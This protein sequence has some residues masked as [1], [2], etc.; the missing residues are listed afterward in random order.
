MDAQKKQVIAKLKESKNILVTVSNNPSIDQLAACLGLSLMLNKLGKHASAVFSGEIPSTLDFLKPEETL[1]TNTNSLRDFI[2]ALDRNKADKLR[3]KVEDKVVRIFITPYRTSISQDDLN[4]SEG[5][6]NVDVVIAL[7]VKAQQDIDRA[8]TEHGNIL[9]DA[10]VI[11]LTTGDEPELGS[12]HWRDP[13]ASGV[14][15]LAASLADSFD[16]NVLDEQIA[17]AF[18]T[19][20]VARTNRFS[21]ELTSS[22]T[23]KI[24][25]QLMGA[26]A[27]QQLV[28]SELDKPAESSQQ[29][30]VGELP[31]PQIS[32]EVQ[33]DNPVDPGLLKIDHEESGDSSQGIEPSQ[34]EPNQPPEGAKAEPEEPQK[35][36]ERGRLEGDGPNDSLLT[37]N[38]KEE[39]LEGTT[40][41]LSLADQGRGL[42]SHGKAE[43]QK[44]E[45]VK[46]EQ[47]SPK[48]T[49]ET[50][51]P[52]QNDNPD[53]KSD[54]HETL[55]ELEADVHSPHL[56]GTTG[57]DSLPKV[58][59]GE[60]G[61]LI[62]H[63]DE[64]PA[65]EPP[66]FKPAPGFGLPDRPLDMKPQDTSTKPDNDSPLPPMSPPPVPPPMV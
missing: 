22:Q 24:S 54:S 60:D 9:H 39:P 10:T 38:S 64:Q 36:F 6:F 66:Q 41:P 7:G 43:K 50:K 48:P 14:S 49:P 45:P 40:D 56:K 65:N 29:D 11:T 42:M 4:F 13:G 12:I 59:I 35:P 27:N 47:E 1:E 23:M 31:E 16:K 63:T 8:V 34:N 61:L 2:I 18:L 5:D 21:N 20:I 58:S 30:D 28:A 62:H 25:A 57:V 17:T 3:Y 53:L 26:G 52:G 32:D 51:E 55:D 33:P 15:E 19:G 37:A 46:P 44:I